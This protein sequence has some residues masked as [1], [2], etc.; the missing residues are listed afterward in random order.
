[1]QILQLTPIRNGKVH[2]LKLLVESFKLL[3]ARLLDRD[4]GRHG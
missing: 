4:M 1:M 3:S 2:F